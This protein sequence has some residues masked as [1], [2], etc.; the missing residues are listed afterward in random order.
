MV[1]KLLIG[2]IGLILIGAA[3]Y[4]FLGDSLPAIGKEPINSVRFICDEDK[5]IDADFYERE[6]DLVFSD[7]RT[8]TL[9]QAISASGARYA[10]ENESIVFWNKGDTAFVTEGAQGETY[11]NCEVE[12]PGQEA[13]STYAS[14]TMGITFK[15]PKSFRIDP[16]YQYTGFPKKP[17]LGVKALVPDTMAT[18]TNLSSFDTG[19][20][21]EQLPRAINC[22]GDIFIEDDVKASTV[23]ENGVTYSVA[24]T[25]GAGAGNRYEETVYA[26][27]GSKPCT[28]IR[29]FIHYAAIENFGPG[30]VHEFDRAGLIAAFDNIR[31]SVQ[32]SATSSSQ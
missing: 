31:G 1:Q 21:V 14:S 9:P 18:G 22:T 4:Y 25:S 20:S 26:M 16:A 6:V 10:T 32:L 29:Y 2:V 28:A 17:I 27:A 30:V 19:L 8:M 24:S 23:Q 11:S 13:R 3:A 15:Y 5:T 12:V 7:G